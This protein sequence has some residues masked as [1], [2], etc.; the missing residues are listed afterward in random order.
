MSLLSTAPPWDLVAE[1]YSDITMPLF[2]SYAEAALD[3]VS[4][5][6][7]ARIADIA[8]GPGTLALAAAERVANVTALDF[9]ER[10]IA[11]LNGHLAT[12]DVANV[13]AIRG[14]GQALPF[15]DEMFDAA[16]S[17]FGLMF[18]PDRPRGYAEL[19]RTLKPRGQVCVSSW[20]PVS[21]SPMMDVIAAALR[22]V[23]PDIPEP[24]Y[25]PTSLENPDV[26]ASELRDAGFQKVAVHPV[27]G[28]ITVT[29]A[30]AF[31]SDMARGAVP[32]TLAKETMTE[33]EWQERSARAVSQIEA[34]AGPFP[35][36][37]SA[38]AWLGMGRK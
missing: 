11:L 32:V 24:V 28:S 26:L 14:D 13:E 37:L 16:F 36:A 38:T 6:A 19:H 8:C 31:W 10:M 15:G 18:F 17:M 5:G 1:G 22:G 2:R 7:G 30:A 20:A 12:R 33:V 25:D 21:R 3:L 9:S 27:E 34:A 35:A 29:S 4:P 23:D